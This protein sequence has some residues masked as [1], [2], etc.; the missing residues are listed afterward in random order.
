MHPVSSE[1]GVL[2]HRGLEELLGELLVSLAAD[3]LGGGVHLVVDGLD[4]RGSGRAGVLV[5][6]VTGRGVALALRGVGELRP[7]D[8]IH[9]VTKLDPR[10]DTGVLRFP[11]GCIP[12]QGTDGHSYVSTR[13]T[14]PTTRVTRYL[15]L[16]DRVNNLVRKHPEPHRI[17]LMLGRPGISLAP[18][19]V[20]VRCDGQRG[21][22]IL[23]PHRVASAVLGG[24]V[25]AR[26]GDPGARTE[27]DAAIAIASRLWIAVLRSGGSS[28]SGTKPALVRG[29][30]DP[31]VL[32]G[33]WLPVGANRPA[34]QTVA[35]ADRG[36]DLER[37]TDPGSLSAAYR[38]RPRTRVY[39]SMDVR[40][41]GPLSLA[42]LLL[43]S[44][45]GCKVVC[46]LYESHAGDATMGEH[47]DDWFGVIVQLD[48]EKRWLLRVDPSGR[49]ES[50]L[51]QAG[52]VLLL[53][54]GVRH[55]SKRTISHCTRCSRYL[56]TS[57]SDTR[58]ADLA[59]KGIGSFAVSG[60]RRIVRLGPG[61][62]I[63]RPGASGDV[64][65]TVVNRTHERASPQPSLLFARM[66]EP[67][68]S[69]GSKVN[70]RRRMVPNS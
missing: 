21:G 25:R 33:L 53:P 26:A 48:G 51:M 14:V 59:L 49:R 62:A 55:E 37:F 5:Q 8:V 68:L 23:R 19:E 47:W 35:L 43:S 69:G 16:V 3:P 50:I 52:D 22:S 27:A 7:D 2:T 57:R 58:T 10:D 36:I 44:A 66:W 64:E 29:V 42:A 38:N 65:L 40:S 11:C 67:V 28:S 34:A 13:A 4:D 1:V 39:E 20:L 24:R 32:H 9:R 31:A 18:D 60:P 63:R 70:Y 41:N 61:A 54:R 17:S 45:A 46:T 15:D 12:H 30:F 6:R 56:C